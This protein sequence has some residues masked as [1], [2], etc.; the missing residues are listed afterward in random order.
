MKDTEPLEP[1]EQRLKDLG[2]P[3][4]AETRKYRETIGWVP[5]EEY[6]EKIYFHHPGRKFDNFNMSQD[7]FD[8]SIEANRL[9]REA[10]YLLALK[11][12]NMDEDWSE[13]EQ[14]ALEKDLYI[15]FKHIEDE[16]AV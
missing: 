4:L 2:L 12:R 14:K 15:R 5:Y 3:T 7:F 9:L 10:A 8:K 1:H 16:F 6:M 13:R 11:N